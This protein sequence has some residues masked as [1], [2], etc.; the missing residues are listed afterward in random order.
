MEYATYFSLNMC[1]IGAKFLNCILKVRFT[2]S[3]DDFAIIYYIKVG[4]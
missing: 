4:Y 1:A 2:F 3:I